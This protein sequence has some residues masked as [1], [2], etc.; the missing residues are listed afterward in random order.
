MPV[1]G[2]RFQIEFHYHWSQIYNQRLCICY[3]E[4]DGRLVESLLNLKVLQRPLVAVVEAQRQLAEH[5][6]ILE[7]CCL[8]LHELWQL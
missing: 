7:Q 8:L 2:G 1:V 5:L 3:V 6:E 4:A